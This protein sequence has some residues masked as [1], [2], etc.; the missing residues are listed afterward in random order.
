MRKT[1]WWQETFPKGLQFIQILNASGQPISI[2]YGERGTGRPVILVHG[3]GTWSYSWRHNIKTLAQHFRVICFD[4]KGYGFSE[5]PPHLEVIGH[6]IDELAQ[7][8]QKLCGEPVVVIAESLGALVA[9][10]TVEAYPTLF[11]RLVLMNV[12]IFPEHLPSWGMRWMV[13]FPLKAIQVFDHLRLVRLVSPLI[14][15]V[16]NQVRREITPNGIKS[17][18]EDIYWLTYPYIEF[19]FA[20]TKLAEDLK[21]GAQEVK[22][23]HEGM[24]NL[25]STIQDR[26]TEI[27]QP[28]LILWGEQ[29]RWFPVN[30][31]KALQSIL[32]NSEMHLLPNCGHQAA[33]GCPNLVNSKILEFLLNHNSKQSFS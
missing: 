17:S 20:I 13:N 16:A 31:G 3:V 6:Q 1:L 8:I 27:T 5:K 14:R 19:P 32:S 18:P 11:T 4:A 33:S 10:A 24:P 9:L 30:H 29:E 21:Q 7:I 26:L 23:L 22:L 12:P 25:I 28:T 2:A 15:T